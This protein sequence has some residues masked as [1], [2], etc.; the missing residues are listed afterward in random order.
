MGTYN[1]LL[2]VVRE[3]GIWV[4]DKHT[5]RLSP[6]VFRLTQS[7]KQH[8]DALGTALLDC[9]SGVGR[10]AVIAG[11]PELGRSS[12]WRM[13]NKALWS[14]VPE[15]FKQTYS[16]RPNSTPDI[17]KV[18]MIELEDGGLKI[19]EIDGYNERGLGYGILVNRFRSTVA[20]NAAVLPGVAKSLLEALKMRKYKGDVLLLYAN[21]ERFYKSEFR[22]F[23]EE[24]AKYGI[25]IVVAAEDEVEYRNGALVVREHALKGN[26]LVY[27]PFMYDNRQLNAALQKL[28]TAGEIEY[29]MPPKPFLGSKAVMALLR[30]DEGNPELEHILRSQ[31]SESSLE[32]VRQFIPETYLVHRSVK[33]KGQT[34]EGFVLKKTIASGMK[35][36]FFPE[37]ATFASEL[38]KAQKSDFTHVLQREMRSSCR[39]YAYFDGCETLSTLMCYNRLVVHFIGRQLA[40]VSVTALPRKAVHGAVDSIFMGAV[41][42]GESR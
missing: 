18:D 13:I 3:A 33:T 5:F 15:I 40:D 7:N 35:G 32:V 2:A 8:L 12:I 16:H 26:M 20:P 22:I 27:H 4:D 11:N 28:Y 14:G 1:D 31:I 37:D 25:T 24:V 23:S 30:N 17:L 39:E 36:T 6:E 41:I 10:L 29:L 38:S 9:L 42:E 19:A 21:K 34:L